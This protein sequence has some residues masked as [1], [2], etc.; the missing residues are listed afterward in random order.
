MVVKARDRVLK[1]DHGPLVVGV[2]NATPDSFSDQGKTRSTKDAIQRASALIADGADVIEIGGESNVSNR[3]AVPV[4]EELRRVIPCI[5]EVAS[6][7]VPV[8]VDTYK[9]EIA[10]QA[11]EAGASI[12]NDISGVADDRMPAL[13]AD[14]GAALVLVHTEVGPKQSKWDDSLYGGDVVGAVRASLK[15]S[16]ERLLEAGVERDQIVLDPGPD[17]AKTPQQTASLIGGLGQ[18]VD[19]GYAVMLAASRKDFI[20]ALT[21]KKPSERLAGSLAAASAGMLSGVH[22]LRVHDVAAT[23]DFITVWRAIA[24]DDVVD[25]SL[26]I[27]EEVRRET[28]ASSYDASAGE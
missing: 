14:S 16:A 23:R 5:T 15:A 28:P 13:A 8:A 25:R 3:P 1:A 18:I 19:L 4:D 27:R 17:F 24:G 26:R 10:E 9:P 2:V 22:F 7:G 12:I 11:L 21:G 6:W 20:G